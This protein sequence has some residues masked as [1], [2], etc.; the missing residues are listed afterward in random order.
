MKFSN[1]DI[2]EYYNTTQN[3]YENWWKLKDAHAL[4]YGIWEEHTKN[5]TEA[6]INTNK[7][8]ADLAQI[9]ASDHVLDAGC[10]VGGTAFYLAKEKGT[11]V[12]G[13]SLS[14]KQLNTANKTASSFNL[15]NRVTFHNMDYCN[16]SFPDASFDVIWACESMCHAA[17]KNAFLNECY[18][19]LKK[20]GRLIISDYFLTPEKED[21]KQLITKWIKTWGV[22][23]VI[24]EKRFVEFAYQSDFSD[25]QF[26]D[27]TN[28][29]QRSAKRM[30]RFSLAG[31][32]PSE[33]YNLFN[34][35]VSR[36]A[37]TH[38]KCGYYQYKAL[39]AGL[40]KYKA[41]LAVK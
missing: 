5:F 28:N 25:V 3:H 35:K 1:D 36:F 2:A 29:I 14:E 32:I 6:L 16:T 13:I 8:L 7:V 4:H 30:Y 22:P 38:Y 27:F 37:K 15:E 9:T 31:M 12:T 10:G 39:R 33:L 34:P 18:R 17:E 21:N 40:W 24:K 23:H 19:L 20:G 11:T 41:V 26:F